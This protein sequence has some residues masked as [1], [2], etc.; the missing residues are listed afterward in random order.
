M[1][2]FQTND[3]LIIAEATDKYDYI[4]ELGEVASF[5]S[6][7]PYI[8]ILSNFDVKRKT[9]KC[10]DQISEKL[11]QKETSG[12]DLIEEL[13]AK[14]CEISS[15][16]YTCSANKPEP[17][18]NLIDGFIENISTI[19]SRKEKTLSFGIRSLDTVLGPMLPGEYIVLAAT[20]SS[21]KTSLA[22]QMA[23]KIASAGTNVLF[24]SLETKKELLTGK[25]IFINSEQC[26]SDLMSNLPAVDQSKMHKSISEVSGLNLW[27]DDKPSA[28]VSYITGRLDALKNKIKF[29]LVIID[30][31]HLMSS[32]GKSF[33]RHD[34]LT[35]ISSG[36]K[37]I[38]RRYCPV[39]ALCQLNKSDVK[40]DKYEP[41]MF[42]IRESGSI[43][44]DADKILMLHY[45][46]AINKEFESGCSQIIVAKNKIGQ[47]GKIPLRFHPTITRF[48]DADK[49]VYDFWNNYRNKKKGFF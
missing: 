23:L 47:T 41:S 46:H 45:P 12:I 9:Q 18:G 25:T 35:Q 1:V 2:E 38:T 32:E 21:G 33:S 40:D 22:L 17:I 42:D 11:H 26:Y 37:E 13:S 3:I 14:T 43:P 28:K 4:V 36:I 48:E 39:L 31:V 34:A 8:K 10:I 49:D 6:L 20:P 16:S 19:Y 44:Q 15:Q 27:I 7:S 24:F 30:H 5:A 29:G